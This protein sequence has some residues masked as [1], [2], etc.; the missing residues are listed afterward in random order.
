MNAVLPSFP[1]RMPSRKAR[2]V[3]GLM[4]TLLIGLMTAVPSHAIDMVTFSGITGPLTSAL[5]LFAALA[6][7]IKALIGFIGFAVAL[8]T[9]AAL[10][11]FGA[12]LFYIGLCIFGAVGLVM[13]G[14]VMGAVI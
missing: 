3:F 2:M 5:A 12:V 14:A 13:G 1:L 7:G 11:N 8:I 9:L 10:R 4:A 6:P